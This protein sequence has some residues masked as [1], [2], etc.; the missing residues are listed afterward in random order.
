MAPGP[1][2]SGYQ[3][4]PGDFRWISRRASRASRLGGQP[5]TMPFLGFVQAVDDLVTDELLGSQ[6]LVAERDDEVT[7]V[8]EERV[9]VGFGLIQ[10][11]LDGR[12]RVLVGEHLAH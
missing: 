7:V 10:K 5:Q 4:P 2:G 11:L 8:V 6:Q 1:R 12:P 3:R 9:G